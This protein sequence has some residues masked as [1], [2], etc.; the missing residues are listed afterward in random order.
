MR[1]IGL[2]RALAI[3]SLVA[4]VCGLSAVTW[5]H[6]EL[7]YTKKTTSDGTPYLVVSG[8]FDAS[9]DLRKFD[10]AVV[11]E[12]PTAISFD[13]PGGSVV[14]S[15]ELGRKIRA[16]GL[17]TIQARSND[18][19]SACSLAFLGGVKRFAEPGSIGVHKSSFSDTA[20]MDIHQAVSAVQQMTAEVVVYMA[21][22]G[23][24]AGLL[25]LSLSY[26]SD[27]IRY[28]SGSEMKKFRVT[29][30]EDGIGQP[31]RVAANDPVMP[32]AEPTAASNVAPIISL[33]IPRPRN[34]IIQHPKGE[35][36]LKASADPNSKSMGTL[37]NGQSVEIIE[38][39]GDW[40]SVSSGMH[41]GYMHYSWVWVREFEECQFGKRYV[42]IKSYDD[43]QKASDFVRGS[44]IPLVA[45]LAADGWFAI[46]LAQTMDEETAKSISKSLK[47]S[48]SIPKD[49]MIT[50]GNTYVRKVCCE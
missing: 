10:V 41:R 31:D 7:V 40:Y 46:T 3:R 20:G 12:H 21:E 27:D 2:A 9:D 48:N 37:I 50:F 38:K 30:E 14:K 19:A 23:V 47:G 25:Q 32:R 43:L 6:A 49:S 13:S 18:C 5:A 29:T 1:T 16:A 44:S 36:A 4:C 42:Q 11:Q 17:P 28:L 24:D 39:A 22:M 8:R 26:D 45:H 35:A 34:G 33:A 15:I